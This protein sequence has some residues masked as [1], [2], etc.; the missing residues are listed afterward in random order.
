MLTLSMEILCGVSSIEIRKPD[1]NGIDFQPSLSCR[2]KILLPILKVLLD[3][4]SLFYFGVEMFV[5]KSLCNFFL[6]LKFNSW[7]SV[8]RSFIEFLRIAPYDFFSGICFF[9]SWFVCFSKSGD[10]L[11]D[12]AFAA[13]MGNEDSI[14]IRARFFFKRLLQNDCIMSVNGN[15][16]FF[17]MP[18][19]IFAVE[20]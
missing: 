4:C 3:S 9:V 17:L 8:Q 16:T 2:S 7:F 18:W 1:A 14:L 13:N 11:I 10:Y 20:R 6:S 5:F 19:L 15:T 12:R